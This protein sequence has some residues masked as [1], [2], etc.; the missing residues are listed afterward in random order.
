MIGLLEG[1]EVH[2]NRSRLSIL[3]NR[4]NVMQHIHPDT[5]LDRGA[6]P[7][8]VHSIQRYIDQLE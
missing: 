4:Y 1:H 5:G 7:E 3:M 2:W 6:C 8:L